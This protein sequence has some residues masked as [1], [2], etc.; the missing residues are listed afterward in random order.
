MARRNFPAARRAAPA[1]APT[2]VA[3]SSI[4][5]APDAFEIGAIG[6]R[7]TGDLLLLGRD[8]ARPV[9]GRLADAPAEPGGVGELVGEAAGVDV[10]LLR[11][12]AADDAG[13]AD[14]ALLGD[15]RLRAMP[16]GDARRP[17]AARA[18]ADDEEVDVE[19]HRPASS[20]RSRRGRSR[21]RRPSSSFPRGPGDD[22]GGE[23]SAARLETS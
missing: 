1:A 16:G 17:H 18:C 22:V 4:S 23:L 19:S 6:G 2:I 15:D 5:S 11:H 13:A 20:R 10:K 12:A 21:S 9:E 8:E 7:K 3:R 14:P